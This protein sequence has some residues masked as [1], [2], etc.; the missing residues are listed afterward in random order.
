MDSSFG[1]RERGLRRIRWA[2][3]RRAEPITESVSQSCRTAECRREE[4]GQ[5]P[6]HE[7]H[8]RDHGLSIAPL[9]YVNIIP[10]LGS[11][12][13]IARCPTRS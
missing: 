9:A 1:A 2:F 3:S 12:Y 4:A 8:Q 7:H 6:A 11:L 5:E 10:R 13:A